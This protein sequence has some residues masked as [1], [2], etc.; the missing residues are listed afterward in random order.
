MPKQRD[1]VLIPVPYSDLSTNKKRPVLIL[2]SDDALRRSTDMLVAAITSN[3]G[4]GTV[5][6]IIDTADLEGGILPRRSLIRADKIYT[7][8]QSDIVKP[9][10]VLSKT[11]FEKVL[12]ELD[13]VLGR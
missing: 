1:I 5:G 13:S 6:V 7:L 3:L 8:R 4:A 2:S 12:A 9:Y 10:G 11:T